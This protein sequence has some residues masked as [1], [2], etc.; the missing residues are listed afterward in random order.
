MDRDSLG[1][2]IYEIWVNSRMAPDAFTDWGA[3]P[4]H[5]KEV[6]F[7]IIKTV[8]NDMVSMICS[9]LQYD[10]IVEDL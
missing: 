3:L 1:R 6:W 5:E 4:D 10:K 9:N 7:E 2:T 8:S